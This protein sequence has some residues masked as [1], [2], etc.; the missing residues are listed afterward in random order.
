TGAGQVVLYPPAG[1]SRSINASELEDGASGLT[2]RLG[3]G[4]GDWRLLIFA[5]SGLDIEAMTLLDQTPR[6]LANLSTARAGD[7]EIL[8]FPSTADPSLRGELRLASRS[9]SGEVRISAI[10]EAG[11]VFG[12]VYLELDREHTVTLDSYDL[13]FGND[14]KGLT[15]GLG[16]GEGEWRLFVQSYLDLDVF[17]YARTEDGTIS[18]VADAALSR[19]R[20]HHVPLFNA[21]SALHTSRLRLINPGTES[22]SIRIQ[23]W[24][25]TGQFAPNGDVRLSLPAETT[26]TLDALDLQYGAD[27]ADG[28]LGA[29]DGNWR[30]LV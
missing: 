29:G 9:G 17:S 21:A 22:A 16:S 19:D 20:R 15:T 27:G 5:D 26:R 13:E 3:D 1:S 12:P 18:A 2:G 4:E 30:L 14:A 7:G 10:D 28:S 8:L 11:Q 25:D 23:A 24:D 6:A